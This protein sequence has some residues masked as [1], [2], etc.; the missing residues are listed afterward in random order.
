MNGRSG[1]WEMGL[2]ESVELR[3]IRGKKNY[4]QGTGQSENCTGE[5]E[6]GR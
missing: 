1:E 4:A 2:F 3:V 6:S 5:V